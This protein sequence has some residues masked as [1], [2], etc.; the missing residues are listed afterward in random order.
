MADTL[1]WNGYGTAVPHRLSIL[2]V[3]LRFY[4]V[5]VN[6]RVDRSLVTANAGGRI[7]RDKRRSTD[8]IPDADAHCIGSSRYLLVVTG[9]RA[10]GY[11]AAGE[12]AKS[13]VSGEYGAAT[14]STGNACMPELGQVLD[15][16]SGD[17]V[18][19]RHF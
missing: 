17:R 1:L 6:V 19:A 2:E 8:S 7:S 13:R 4:R 15:G 18:F 12:D 11:V 9:R 5:R 16:P 3:I 14:V 10:P